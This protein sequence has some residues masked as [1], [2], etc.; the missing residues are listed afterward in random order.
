MAIISAVGVFFLSL[1]LKK[2]SDS[3]EVEIPEEPHE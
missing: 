3:I 2:I 1:F